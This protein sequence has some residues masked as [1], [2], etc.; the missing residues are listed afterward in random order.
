MPNPNL[1][2][3][4]KLYEIASDG[5]SKK[6]NLA[7]MAAMLKLV[8]K[9]RDDI[10]K[11]HNESM[12]SMD[13]MYKM[14]FAKLNLAGLE[15]RVSK[16][17]SNVKDGYTPVKGKDYRDGK[18]ADVMD[19]V[20]KVMNLVKPDDMKAEHKKEMERMCDEMEKQMKEE[21]EKMKK[22]IEAVKSRPVKMGMRKIP[23]VK[24]IDLTS[25]TNGVLRSFALPRDTVQV[26]CVFGTDFPM[27]FSDSDFTLTGNTLTLA[28]T[29]D[30]PQTGATLGCLIETLFYG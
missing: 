5:V 30:P 8:V 27:S 13:E 20:T 28:S 16:T 10:E 26:L 23:V 9:L 19:A 1:E 25:Q 4:K 2:K 21:M 3:L 7:Q 29:F 11:K 24:R 14:M 17:L 6:E 12:K 15:E 22:D 18:D